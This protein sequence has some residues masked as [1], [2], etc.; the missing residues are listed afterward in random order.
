MSG[1]V[2][3]PLVCRGSGRPR[4]ADVRADALLL[5][6][7]AALPHKH[8]L[9]T[10]TRCLQVGWPLA[11]ALV[12]LL[13]DEPYSQQRDLASDFLLKSVHHTEAAAAAL[14]VSAS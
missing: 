13:D 3:L 7:A 14:H 10:A 4:H 9:V 2:P 12:C 6:V 11:T 5:N 8:T 1:W